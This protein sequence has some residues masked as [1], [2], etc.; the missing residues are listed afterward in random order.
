MFLMIYEI[1]FYFF[2]YIVSLRTY[3]KSIPWYGLNKSDDELSSGTLLSMGPGPADVVEV[4]MSVSNEKRL[5][6]MVFSEVPN[7]ISA[8]E[9]FLS[10]LDSIPKYSKEI[11][12]Y[13]NMN[14]IIC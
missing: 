1:I 2:L 12:N 5:H 13:L 7:T 10:N 11:I 4:S 14:K 8:S 6:R 9:S 3:R